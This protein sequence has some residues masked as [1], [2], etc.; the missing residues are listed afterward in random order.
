M[1]NV[2]R[3]VE[4]FPDL[5]PGILLGLIAGVAYGF[6]HDYQEKQDLPVSWWQFGGLGAA[7]G[8]LAWALL[9]VEA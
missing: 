6:Y 5:W 1:D 4:Q 8:V 9:V 3:L 2:P 7:L